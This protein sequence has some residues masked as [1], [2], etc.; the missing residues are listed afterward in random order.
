MEHS[1]TD[2]VLAVPSSVSHNARFQMF[3]WPGN[4]VCRFRC[5]NRVVIDIGPSK[6]L[7]DVIWSQLPSKLLHLAINCVNAWTILY[8]LRPPRMDFDGLAQDCPKDNVAL[9]DLNTLFPALQTLVLQG[10]HVDSNNALVNDRIAS[11]L[12]RTLTHFVPPTYVQFSQAG[13]ASMPPG[14]MALSIINRGRRTIPIDSEILPRSLTHLNFHDDLLITSDCKHFPNTLRKLSLRSKQLTDACVQWLPRELSHLSI[15]YSSLAGYSSASPLPLFPSKL[16]YLKCWAPINLRDEDVQHLP[17]TLVTLEFR[18][19][20]QLS[21]AGVPFLPQTLTHLDINLNRLI[22]DS[23]VP[24]LPRGLKFLSL[25]WTDK[26]TGDSAS[27][28]PPTLTHLALPKCEY[29]GDQHIRHLPRTI[30]YLSLRSAKLTM[31]CKLDLP[32][33]LTLLNTSNPEISSQFAQKQPKEQS[34]CIQ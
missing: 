13:I 17:R 11:C 30:K 26:I 19:A 23:S 1:V 12:P 6:C 32:P 28:L 8:D 22:S 25:Q 29:F 16:V 4:F 24:L 5:L 10:C 34:C 7:Q 18:D 20:M 9:V 3:D 21:D 31:A 27:Q 2:I 15:E 14:I 33:G